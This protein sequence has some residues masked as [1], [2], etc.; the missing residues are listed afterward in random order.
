MRLIWREVTDECASDAEREL[1]S[2][3]AVM[4]RESNAALMTATY[5]KD[6]PATHRVTVTHLGGRKFVALCE[7][8]DMVDASKNG[9]TVWLTTV[10][11]FWT[12]VARW[13][14]YGKSEQGD[15]VTFAS[16]T[17][18]VKQHE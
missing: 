6:G 5:S 17:M 2:R 12:R 15:R 18:E 11:S 7:R 16:V 10:N 3:L 9:S 8:F 4:A 14:T 1:A 13:F